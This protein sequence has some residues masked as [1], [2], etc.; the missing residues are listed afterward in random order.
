MLAGWSDLTRIENLVS[1]LRIAVAAACP[2]TLRRGTPIRIQRMAEALAERGHEVHVVTY[3]LGG[4]D[5]SAQLRVHRT[6]EDRHY[7]KLGP[8]PSVRK[9]AVV[10]R[11]LY[12]LL[13]N[14]LREQKIDIIH[15][16]HYE[17]L[18]SSRMALSQVTNHWRMSSASADRSTSCCHHPSRNCPRSLQR[19]TWP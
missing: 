1:P 12:H 2:F 13:K 15:A 6:P 3:H 10:D 7:A 14:V 19:P 4:D 17:G 11:A 16:H 9:L 8:G 18:R 5:C